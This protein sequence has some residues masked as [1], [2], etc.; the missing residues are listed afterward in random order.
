[1]KHEIKT[2]DGRIVTLGRGSAQGGQVVS[3]RGSKV[4]I[5][6]GVVYGSFNMVS[7]GPLGARYRA[8]SLHGT[9][10]PRIMRNGNE[11]LHSYEDVARPRKCNR[12][13]YRAF[14]LELE[15]LRKARDLV[16][17]GRLPDPKIL[18]K[19]MMERAA[20][21]ADYDA[22]RKLERD[23]MRGALQWAHERAHAGF[24]GKFRVGL[25]L[26]FKE[27]FDEDIG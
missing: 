8:T 16:D 1:M 14:D 19:K 2:A 27:I 4:I 24:A 13:E 6:E 20:R 22:T 5:I 23:A 7:R 25:A 18:A 15:L 10:L 26:A 3:D 11:S 21:I 12:E 9:W 17:T